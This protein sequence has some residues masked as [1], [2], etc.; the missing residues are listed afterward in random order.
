MHRSWKPESVNADREFESRPHR[1][2]SYKFLRGSNGV[3][4]D[5][6]WKPERC[7]QAAWGGVATAHRVVTESRPHRQIMKNKTKKTEIQNITWKSLNHEDTHRPASWY[8]GLAVIGL[9]LV[10]F[11][12]YN[13]SI[14]MGLTF[15]VGVLVLL[16]VSTQRPHT[17]T[18]KLSSSSI[19]SGTVTY[20]Y[21]AIKKF[22]IIYNPP[23]VKTLN[24]ETT[25]Y[26]NNVI[27]LP[28]GDE[29]PLAIKTFLS[30]Y[31]PEDLDREESLSERLARNLKIW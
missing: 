11:A 30:Q 20:P 14:L 28:L 1:Q 13:H 19:S 2:E 5:E 25:A 29:D 7:S 23:E 10:A 24:F 16:I 15:I 6:I 31:L 17:V 18:Y 27:T 8:L 4:S 22:W 9:G 3:A 12:V 26:L 21:K